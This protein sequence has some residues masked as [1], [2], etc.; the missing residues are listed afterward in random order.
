MNLKFTPPLL[1]LALSIS[2]SA[3]IVSKA[4]VDTVLA[5][6]SSFFQAQVAEKITARRRAKQNSA[7]IFDQEAYGQNFYFPDVGILQGKTRR[8]RIGTVLKNGADDI[9]GIGKI[10]RFLQAEAPLCGTNGTCP[11]SACVCRANRDV[12]SDQCAPVINAVCNGYADKDSKEWNIDGCIND[13]QDSPNLHEYLKTVFC[14][15]S[16]CFDD[17][18]TYGSCFCEF[19]QSAC[20]MLGDERPYTVSQRK[21]IE[22]CHLL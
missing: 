20:K 11:H 9:E 7:A 16:K 17:G 22:L 18:G 12:I 5:E 14:Q 15:L 4:N 10:P 6:R 8:H 19:Y 2:A 13:Y 3:R 1:A 21:A